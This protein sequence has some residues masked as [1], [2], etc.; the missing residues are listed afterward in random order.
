MPSPCPAIYLFVLRCHLS[1]QPLPWPALLL[2]LALHSGSVYDY[3]NY[4]KHESDEWPLRVD[5]SAHPALQV[6]SLR[7][8]QQEQQ[9]QPSTAR[10]LAQTGPSRGYD[11]QDSAT[12]A[13]GGIGGYVREEPTRSRP[14]EFSIPDLFRLGS[15]TIGPCRQICFVS[16]RTVLNCWASSDNS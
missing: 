13:S 8:K 4:A 10:L 2:M 6:P 14:G 15:E 3:R 11:L 5:W 7:P 9:Q 12:D 1:T 16:C